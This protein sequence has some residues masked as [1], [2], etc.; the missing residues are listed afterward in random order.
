[1]AVAM[2]AP[3]LPLFDTPGEMGTEKKEDMVLYQLKVRAGTTGAMT[4]KYKLFVR[5]FYD[6]SP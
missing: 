6:G 5:R 3:S 2:L 4:D 1:M